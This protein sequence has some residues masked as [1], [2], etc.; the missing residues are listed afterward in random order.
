MARR[1][2]LD[3]ADDRP[4]LEVRGPAQR[5]TLTAVQRDA[6]DKDIHLL[7][8]ALQ[9]DGI[10]VSCDQRL[11]VIVEA[12]QKLARK[13]KSIRFVD[14]VCRSGLSIRLTSR[15]KTWKTARAQV[16]SARSEHLGQPAPRPLEHAGPVDREGA[17]PPPLA[18]QSRAIHPSAR[19]VARHCTCEHRARS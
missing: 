4:D 18:R 3:R 14:P 8:A 13:L 2:K 7:E 11:V 16:G 1:G 15:F 19:R 12:V 5:A 6:F 10:V 17:F 9:A